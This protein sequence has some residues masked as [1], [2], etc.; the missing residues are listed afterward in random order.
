[1]HACMRARQNTHIDTYM[2]AVQGRQG[3]REAAQRVGSEGK[4]EE[5]TA[6]KAE[7]VC[8]DH[9]DDAGPSRKEEERGGRRGEREAKRLRAVLE[10]NAAAAQKREEALEKLRQ[11]NALLHDQLARVHAAQADGRTMAADGRWNGGNGDW[12]QT[13]RRQHAME[14]SQTCVSC[15]CVRARVRIDSQMQ[16][17]T[18]SHRW[19]TFGL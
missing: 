11:E 8:R 3:G 19:H 6:T 10:A 12:V 18:P 2:H 13:M 14:V 4:E 5:R 16:T 15:V 1:M 9:Q 7:R 17:H